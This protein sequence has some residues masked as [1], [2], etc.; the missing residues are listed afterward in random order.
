MAISITQTIAFDDAT[1]TAAH[2]KS[3]ISTSAGSQLVLAILTRCAPYVITGVTDSGSNTW[4][5]VVGLDDGS[6]TEASI[7]WTGTGS[8]AA[9]TSFTINQDAGAGAQGLQ[10]QFYEVSL[11][12]GIDQTHTGSGSSTAI[13]SGATT[14]LTGVNDLVIGVG[15]NG[16]I[17][18]NNTYSSSTFTGGAGTENARA[19][20]SSFQQATTGSLILSGSSAAQTYS[21]TATN[22]AGWACVVATWQEGTPPPPPQQVLFSTFNNFQFFDVGNGMGCSEKIK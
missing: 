9:I 8:A 11:L 12:G 6:S 16:F 7:W 13:S 5:K 4:T 2:T 17:F 3:S 1:I 10:S 19:A 22:S 18:A 14:G 20:K 15:G 21:A